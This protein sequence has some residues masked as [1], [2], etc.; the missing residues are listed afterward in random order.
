VTGDES[1]QTHDG[2]TTLM[3]QREEQPTVEASREDQDEQPKRW[4]KVLPAKYWVLLVVVLSIGVHGL[5]ISLHGLTARSTTTE[6][7]E[8]S[9]GTF[10]FVNLQ[11]EGSPIAEAEFELHVSLLSEVD[12]LARPL[13]ESRKFRIEQDVE[14]LLRQVHGADFDDPTLAEL[15]RQIQEKVNQTLEMRG[16]EAVIVTDLTLKHRAAIEPAA[17]PTAKPERQKQARAAFQP[18]ETSDAS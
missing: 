13:L 8:I 4:W 17:A 12:R 6:T 5:L 2:E 3:A 14:E 18:H 10:R 1:I 9:L 7:P 11:P 16:V 15:K